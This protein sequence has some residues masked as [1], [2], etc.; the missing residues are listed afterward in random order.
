MYGFNHCI[1]SCSPQQLG[2]SLFICRSDN[3]KVAVK[4]GLGAYVTKETRRYK[5]LQAHYSFTTDYCNPRKGNEKGL[6]ENLVGLGRRNF[7]VPMPRVNSIDE[8]NSLLLDSCQKYMNHRIQGSVSSVGDNFVLDQKAFT[9]LPVYAYNPQKVFYA[10][11]NSYGLITHAT[12]KYSVPTNLAGKE[13]LMK[14]SA[15]KVDVYYKG[16]SVAQHDRCYGKYQKTYDVRH[17]L[18]LLDLK[19]RA[20]F[21]AAPV[22]Q[23]IPK[24]VLSEYAGMPNGRRLLLEYIKESL[25]EPT[26]ADI[27]VVTSNLHEYDHLIQEVTH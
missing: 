15:S 1:Y 4:E 21:N 17:Y 24:E 2:I 25:N 20:V 12:N 8:V 14:V 3:A 6:V 9:L 5:E 18:S 16:E 26:V 23:H 19:K 11:P 22:R 10:S 7:L 13:V 27:P